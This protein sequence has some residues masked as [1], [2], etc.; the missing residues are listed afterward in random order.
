MTMRLMKVSFLMSKQFL[1]P[2]RIN[3]IVLNI[4]SSPADE[5][6]SF[7]GLTLQ[8]MYAASCTCLEYCLENIIGTRLK[9]LI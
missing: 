4:R 1:R 2:L 5:A 7:S 8:Y 3:P 9:Q 6:K